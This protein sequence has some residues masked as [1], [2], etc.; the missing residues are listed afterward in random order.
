MKTVLIIIFCFVI[1]FPCFASL[2]QEDMLKIRQII[3]EEIEPLKSEMVNMKSDIKAI[4]SKVVKLEN[5]MTT[6]EN[7]MATFENKMATLE[8]KIATKDDLL[9]MWKEI[10]GKI[11]GI[12]GLL[13][14]VLVAIIVSVIL[15][16]ILQ[17][18]KIG[19][20]VDELKQEIAKLKDKRIISP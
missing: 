17:K 5:R 14:G 1:S 7:R 3:R 15:P 20:D 13:V 4:E 8:G 12:Y 10:T 16:P 9:S 19:N 11:E 18:R 6:F 2:T